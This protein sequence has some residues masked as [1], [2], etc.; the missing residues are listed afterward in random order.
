MI[1][2]ETE[3]VKYT[4]EQ[5]KNKV[6]IEMT[7]PLKQP[8]AEHQREAPKMHSTPTKYS[9]RLNKLHIATKVLALC[10]SKFYPPQP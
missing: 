7:I 10:F 1:F 8:V 9:K 3:K 4:R 2:S 6:H 5:E